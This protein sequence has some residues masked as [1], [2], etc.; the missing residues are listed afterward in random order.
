MRDNTG[1]SETEAQAAV[2][3]AREKIA[4]FS[5]S[6]PVACLTRLNE[7]ATKDN[8]MT[9]IP[10]VPLIAS[11]VTPHWGHKSPWAITS[12]RVRVVSI[13]A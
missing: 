7:S 5:M 12:Y 10:N 3:G 4:P 6:P 9:K 8:G 2:N 1:N 13:T 11:N